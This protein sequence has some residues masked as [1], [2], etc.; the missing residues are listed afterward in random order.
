M[1]QLGAA[2]RSAS[3]RLSVSHSA[4]VVFDTVGKLGSGR[5]RLAR[6]TV[7][8]TFFRVAW[9]RGQGRGPSRAQLP[10]RFGERDSG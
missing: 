7:L 9:G 10:K 5:C 3:M 2:V 8:V 6:D 1:R 4:D